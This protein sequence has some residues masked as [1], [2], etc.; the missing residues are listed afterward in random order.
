MER[1]EKDMVAKEGRIT[2]VMQEK[3]EAKVLE[4]EKD[5]AKIT[6]EEKAE[7]EVTEDI[8]RKEKEKVT[9]V[10]ATTATKWD[11]RSGNVLRN[12]I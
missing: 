1:A 9:T 5:T 8:S 7:V 3:E 6:T 2:E 10:D 4:V 12:E 11:T